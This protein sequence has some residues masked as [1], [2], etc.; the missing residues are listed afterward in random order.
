MP[1]EHVVGEA[2]LLARVQAPILAAQPFAVQQVGAGE[3]DG[4]PAA[5]EPLDGLAVEGFGG[6]AVAQQG[7]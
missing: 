6:R 1:A 7:A 4:D 3:M 2:E 5:G